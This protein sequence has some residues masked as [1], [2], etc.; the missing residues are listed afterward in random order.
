MVIDV[1]WLCLF[2]IGAVL[3]GRESRDFHVSLQPDDDGSATKQAIGEAFKRFSKSKGVQFTYDVMW[4]INILCH[5]SLCLKHP[6]KPDV[7]IFPC[8]IK[9]GRSMTTWEKDSN[10]PVYVG[11]RVQCSSHQ[12]IITP[13]S[14]P[15]IQCD[16]MK[17][18]CM[19]A[20]ELWDGGMRVLPKNTP[21]L[22]N[23]EA[24]VEVPDKSR[25]IRSIDIIV[26][27]PV[28]S[29]GD[30]ISF[31]DSVMHM[32][33]STLDKN[34][35]GTITE[36]SY[37]S[38][39]HI[40]QHVSELDSY[41]KKEIKEAMEANQDYVTHDTVQDSLLDLLV[42]DRDSVLFLQSDIRS[43]LCQVLDVP[44]KGQP[45]GNKVGKALGIKHCKNTCELLEQWSFN[46][47]ATVTHFI[48][49]LNSLDPPASDA[50]QVLATNYEAAKGI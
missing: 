24:L 29:Q 31:L 27:G 14:F 42:V 25:F 22:K 48:D 9:K 33:V 49:V 46:R 32:I 41:S 19:L 5:L 20:V 7:Y 35:P 34:S 28:H 26:R 1:V 6:T 44:D 43:K 10:K 11:R 50:I 37:L 15:V 36:I 12:Q 4:G 45:D 13:G 23:I 40:K 21:H 16:A 30:C 8:H 3:P 2:V 18:N 39:C 47:K 38:F 17:S